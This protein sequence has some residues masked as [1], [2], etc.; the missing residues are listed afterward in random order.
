MNWL[1]L[2]CKRGLSED[3]ILRNKDKV[4]WGFISK[5]QNLSEEFVWENK[6]YIRFDFI[7][8]NNLN[9]SKKLQNQII[10]ELLNYEFNRLVTIF[11]SSNEDKYC[12]KVN[13]VKRR[14]K[15]YYFDKFTLYM[16]K[17]YERL[18]ILL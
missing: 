1:K 11:V 13:V 5:F 17:Q 8:E 14:M 15:K 9:Y 4:S 3:F 18:S 2:S 12:T 7:I 10:Y 16:K 6:Q